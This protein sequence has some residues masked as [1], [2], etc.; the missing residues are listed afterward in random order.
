MAPDICT[1]FPKMTFPLLFF[2]LLSSLRLDFTPSLQ[3]VV[4]PF[5]T[6]CLQRVRNYALPTTT[7][8]IV[9]GSNTITPEERKD[10]LKVG[11]YH[12]LVV[13][14]AHFL[15]LK[16]LTKG[17]PKGLRTFPLFLFFLFSGGSAPALRAFTH[18][19]FN[20][21]SDRFRLN[22]SW[23]DRLILST[24]FVLSLFC[25]LFS[26]KSLLLS[27]ICATIFSSPSITSRGHAVFVSLVSK[28]LLT[29]LIAGAV[30]ASESATHPLGWFL[31]AVLSPVM[32][33]ILFP[34]LLCNWILPDLN[35]WV[36]PGVAKV[37]TWISVLSEKIPENL[38]GVSV[39][40][41]VS[42]AIVFTIMF[43]FKFRSRL[44]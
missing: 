20:M 36:G 15:T 11:I 24:A 41:Q 5:Q 8:G 17:L 34:L 37:L 13:S 3:K 6:F 44:G 22:W 4:H 7:E 1:R 14:G 31:G 2:A 28:T 21:L 42:W 27:V 23:V 9:C 30:M 32:G 29:S 25:S 18:L 35:F 38:A 10:F 19:G 33:S 26:A 12:V 40:T 39:S 43:I 16:R